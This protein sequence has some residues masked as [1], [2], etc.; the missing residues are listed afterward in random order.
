MAF[1][2]KSAWIMALALLATGIFYFSVVAAMS[3]AMGSLAPPNLP[4]LAFYTVLLTILAIIG[5]VAIAIFAP[6]D[7]NA[8]TDE[9]ERRIFDR[10][11][12]WSGYTFGAGV[13]LSLGLYLIFHDGNLLFYGV[14]GSLMLSQL[15]EYVFQIVLYRS[16]L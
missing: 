11:A 9:R 1:Q 5:H 4:V 6:K 15:A 3:S 2:E 12:H 16:T 7:A 10:A 8:P 14:F 13:I